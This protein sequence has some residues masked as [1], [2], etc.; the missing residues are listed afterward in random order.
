MNNRFYIFLFF[1][2]WFG[3]VCAGEVPEEVIR[4]R[5]AGQ[6]E[7][8]QVNLTE[9]R[10]R[11]LD[12]RRELAGKID[13]AYKRLSAARQAAGKKQKAL[14][15][16][17]RQ[18]VIEKE[19]A[20]ESRNELRK[21]R[22]YLITDLGLKV[23]P[24][25]TVAEVEK[26]ASEW[27]EVKLSGYENDMSVTVEDGEVIGRDGL[28]HAALVLSLGNFGAYSCGET[29]KA[30]G[31][32]LRE[33][34][35]WRVAGPWLS[36]EQ[37]RMLRSA[38][39]GN[40]A[41]LPV[42]VRGDLA[43]REPGPRENVL[44]WLD[45][46]G[47]FIYPIFSAG[48]MGI[49]LILERIVYLLRNR[50]SAALIR[51]VFGLLEVGEIDKA[52]GVLQGRDS[53][54]KRVLR[55]VLQAGETDKETQEASIEAALLEEAPAYERSLAMLA[56]LAAIAPL[57]GLLGTVS[58]MIKTF[59][60]ISLIGSSNPRLLSGGISEA[61]LTTQLGLLIAIPLLLGH[62]WLQRWVQRR[63]GQLEHL[64]IRALSLRQGDGADE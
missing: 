13:E 18:L 52:R 62:T 60:M 21:M 39:A 56:T 12:E 40:L 57:L 14:V 20:A 29:D 31:L 37:Q 2:L 51:D 7:K 28:K 50:E 5:A 24:N 8:A 44:S 47:M 10:Q 55:T 26:Q 36:M 54:L 4:Q 58:G 42:D 9:M 16:L 43:Q 17:E 32:L 22:E 6:R 23:E 35:A 30:C 41:V 45:A 27:L 19:R 64:A 48:I 34:N 3:G 53:P 63:E 61:L 38:A 25:D 59:N 15:T 49:L 1:A 11:I 46:G 33:N